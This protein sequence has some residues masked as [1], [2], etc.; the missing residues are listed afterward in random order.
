MPKTIKTQWQTILCILYKNCILFHNLLKVNYN[1]FHFHQYFN[2][3][4]RLIYEL[5]VFYTY[6]FH[7]LNILQ[8]YTIYHIRI[9]IARIPKKY[10]ITYSFVNYFFAFT[11]AFIF[12]P[13]LLQTLA[14]S[15]HL[16]LQVSCHSIRF[17]LLVLDIRLNTSTFV[18]LTRS[19]THNLAYRSDR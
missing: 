4:L 11:S 18:L 19:E 8:H 14:S 3:I 5:I 12:V 2:Y 16:H 10:F 13:T 15:L 9:T 1:T 17:V 7:N 6:N